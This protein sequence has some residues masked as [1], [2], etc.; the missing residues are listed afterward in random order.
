MYSLIFVSC[1]ICKLINY[2]KCIFES[3]MVRFLEHRK[4]ICIQYN[5]YKKNN[6]SFDYAILLNSKLNLTAYVVLSISIVSI[7]FNRKPIIFGGFLFIAIVLAL[8]AHILQWSAVLF[9]VVLAS[10]CYFTFHSKSTYIK[11]IC[12]VIVVIFSVLASPLHKIPGVQNW[13]LVK[14]LFISQDAMPLTLFLNFDHPLFGLFILG[15]GSIPLLKTKTEWLEMFKKAIPV[16]VI[17]ILLVYCLSYFLGYVRY[18]LKLNS[19][20]I[21]W[22]LNNLLFICIAEEALFRGLIQS[23]ISTALRSYRGG[24]CL[25]LLLAS[26]LFGLKHYSG[27]VNYI[28]LASFAG[29]FYGYVYKKTK[30]IESSIITHFLL[31]IVHFIGF[32]YPSLA[33]KIVFNIQTLLVSC[34]YSIFLKPAFS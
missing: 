17:G 2:F 8:F 9:I 30:R 33:P 11:I 23:S 21:I 1:I 34:W 15:F 3:D 14:D 10:S 27:G 18:D 13:L 29:L 25:A 12:G 20:F 16:A 26:V 7:W 28:V 6:M 22:S 5:F 32:T 24:D 31:N 19:F 4:L